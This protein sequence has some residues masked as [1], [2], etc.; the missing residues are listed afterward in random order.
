[1]TGYEVSTDPARVDLEVVARFLAD[2]SYWAAGRP[3]DVVARSLE[4]SAVF[5]V[6]HAEDGMVAFARVVT[7]RTTFGWIADLFVVPEHRGRGVG[8]RLVQAIVEDPDLGAMK[9]L[10]LATDDAHR[11]Y[12]DFGFVP[13]EGSD[14]WMERLGPGR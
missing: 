12:A 3:P 9:R 1:L 13:L 10:C 5:T 6:Q 4:H 7:D 8:H 14:R 11:L 2:E